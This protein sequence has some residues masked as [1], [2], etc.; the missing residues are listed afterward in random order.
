MSSLI[1]PINSRRDFD[2]LEMKLTYCRGHFKPKRLQNLIRRYYHEQFN[3]MMGKIMTRQLIAANFTLLQHDR[4][5]GKLTLRAFEKTKLY[6]EMANFVTQNGFATFADF[7]IR[8]KTYFDMLDDRYLC[9][10]QPT[11]WVTENLPTCCS[12]VFSDDEEEEDDA[13]F[14]YI[15]AN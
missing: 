3:R 4:T 6:C 8:L 13:R 14:E 15:S 11:P 9:S 7:V 12:A 1:A 5:G 10:T 2:D